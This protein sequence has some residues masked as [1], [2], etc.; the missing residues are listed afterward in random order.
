MSIS[1]PESPYIISYGLDKAIWNKNVIVKCEYNKDCL[2]KDIIFERYY[3]MTKYEYFTNMF[4]FD[5]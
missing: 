3:W 4:M 2:W 1:R 5:K